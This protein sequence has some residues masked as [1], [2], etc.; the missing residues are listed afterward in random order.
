MEQRFWDYCSAVNTYLKSV[1]RR[2][3]KDV[4]KE[5]EAH[6]EDH[7]DALMSA[8]CSPEDAVTAALCAMG[9][10]AE[11]GSALAKELPSVWKRV[12]VSAAVL[13][14]CLLLFFPARRFCYAK[15]PRVEISRGL[16]VSA[17]ETRYYEMIGIVVLGGSR[18]RISASARIEQN[19]REVGDWCNTV[20]TEI[21]TMLPNGPYHICV[22]G[23][24]GHGQTTLR[25]EG[26]LTDERGNVLPYYEEKT[27]PYI[28]DRTPFYGEN[29]LLESGNK[30]KIF[31]FLF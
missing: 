29:R 11:V 5:L 7:A 9:D 25:Y 20:D 15:F 12:G 16:P 3:K 18:E 30:F 8:G 24:A 13:L 23:E 19:V 28:L 21:R 26:Y 27:F 6:L 2:Q 1:P 14:C 31:G 17:D 22:S 10:P 4:A